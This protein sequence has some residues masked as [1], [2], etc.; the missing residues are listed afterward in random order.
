MSE[1][2]TKPLLSNVDLT[3]LNAARGILDNVQ[4]D[5]QRLNTR[6]GGFAAARAASAEH[7]IFQAISAVNIYT[8]QP[9]TE[10]QVHNGPLTD[11]VQT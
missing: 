3:I 9:M 10:E 5:A 11:E 8:D 7:A 6:G 4:S 1:V 2:T